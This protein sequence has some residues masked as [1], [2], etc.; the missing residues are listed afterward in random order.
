MNVLTRL[1]A[2]RRL[3]RDENERR[4][5]APSR[6]KERGAALV[7]AAFVYPLLFLAIFGVVEF[8]MAFKDYLSVSHAARDGARAGATYGN[9]PTAD[10]LILQDV[11]ATLG[12]V[13][14]SEG[15]IV[16]VFNP[17]SGTGTSYDYQPGYGS[18][19]DWNPCPDPDRGPGPP[20]V[21]PTWN[22]ATRDITA[23]FTERI[24][25]EVT[26]THVWITGFFFGTTD[27][28]VEADFQ[29][30]PQVFDA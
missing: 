5:S 23:P 20:Y 9:A 2:A 8:G 17:I 14:L 7:E 28:V 12:T 15:I 6:K 21:V 24:A 22:P 18:G 19:C 11:G 16:R 27:L 26:Y 13:G 3:K 30:E 25:V 29:I 4:P 10:F 1:K